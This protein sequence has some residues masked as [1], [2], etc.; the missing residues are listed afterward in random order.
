MS[1]AQDS[2]VGSMFGP[3][4]LKRLLGRGGMGE[5]YEA[6]HTVKEWTV[7]VKLMTAEFSKDPVFRERMKR[8]AR[9]AGRLQ[10]PHVVPIHDY[11]E[12]DGQMFL[13]M[14][15]VEGTDLDSV[16]KRFGP[17][18]PPRAVAIITQIAS[19]LDAAHADG[20]MHRDVKP[21]NILITRDDFA[22]LV[23]FGIASA[24]TDEKL[25]Q[26]GTAVGTWK[27]M[28]P[29]RFSND[30]VT[31][32][33]DIYALACV[34][35]EC[36][37]GAPPY[38]ADSAG[39]LVSS[40][41]MG[42]IPQPSA[43]RPGIPK[44]FDAVVARGMAKKP[45]DRYA[46]VV[47]AHERY[48][49]T[50]ADKP[51]KTTREAL[52]CGDYGLKVAGQLV[53]AVERKALADLTSGVLNGN[54]KYQLTELAA[55]PRAAVVVEDRYSEIFAHSFARPTAIADG[56]AEL[57]IGFPNVPIVFCQTRKLAQE[58]TYRYLAAALTWFVDDADATT[59]FEPAAAE[60]EPSSAELRAWAKS[61]G[62]PVSDRGRLRPQILQAWR[63]AHPR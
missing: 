4:H 23:D 2:R 18:T 61:V 41:L 16:L 56:L 14:R 35:H 58:Y 7:A 46:S 57:Q 26:L 13:E 28:A 42:P 49:Y 59:V 40:H 55:L 39:T 31:Y 10:E 3:Y 44:A 50:F 19:A 21:Q 11:G 6:E 62:L 20:V 43:I 8:E 63:A 29:E 34:L 52:P 22:Y 37:T 48:P 51:A 45:E 5:V 24:T 30:E 36:L 1:D 33:A 17:L 9:I 54:L 25:T 47:D 27:Y 15:L 60:P 32:R 12:V 38:R 53:A